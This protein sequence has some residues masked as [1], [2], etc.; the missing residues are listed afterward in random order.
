MRGNSRS[1]IPARA[2]AATL[3]AFGMRQD[4]TSTR[5]DA[6]SSHASHA[7]RLSDVTFQFLRISV[8]RASHFDGSHTGSAPAAHARAISVRLRA[9]RK[10]ESSAH[11]IRPNCS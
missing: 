7:A 4:F 11:S 1:T 3:A 2:S 10:R 9:V 5:C 6:R 8:L